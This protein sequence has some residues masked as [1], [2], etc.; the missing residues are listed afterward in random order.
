MPNIY[1]WQSQLDAITRKAN[2]LNLIT[3]Q[4]EVINSFENMASALDMASSRMNILSNANILSS[5]WPEHFEVYK[6]IQHL[7]LKSFF[8]N[9]SV[10]R[11][12][13]NFDFYAITSALG[14]FNKLDIT[15]ALKNASSALNVYDSLKYSNAIQ[16]VFDSIEWK[17]VGQISDILEKVT[18]QYI[19][20]NEIDEATSEEI[21]E[22]VVVG[23]KE[24]LTDKQRKTWE[25]YIYPFLI[26][27]LF[28]ILSL[29]QPQPAESN[30]ITEINNYYT[31]EI[32]IDVS[33]LN[34]CNFRIIC[35]DNV[36]PR[37]KPDCCSRVVGHLPKGKV[38]C[39]VN[40]YKKWIEITWKNNDGEIYS[41]WIQNYKVT[42]FK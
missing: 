3:D 10:K 37:I 24:L 19:E 23:K 39:V 34:D 33:T 11:M 28:F 18:E 29:K 15:S 26:S 22:V 36:M 2:M 6:A 38:V 5:V 12:L 14:S 30:S 9:D 25:V 7:D 32:G 35:E 21:R 20:E 1:D 17:S 42:S 31:V 41:G 16:S 40:R 4:M 27:L 13:D 8:M